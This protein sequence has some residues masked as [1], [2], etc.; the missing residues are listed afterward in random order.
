MKRYIGIRHRVKARVVDGEKAEA[1][2]T[3]VVILE[4]NNE[5]VYELEDETG[6]LDFLRGKFPTATRKVV[7][8]DDLEQFDA[9]QVKWKKLKSL[10]E[11]DSLPP[12]FVKSEGTGKSQEWFVATQVPTAF[13]GLRSGDT[14][15]MVLGGS[16]DYFAFALSVQGDKLRTGGGE[17]ATVIRIPPFTLKDH[18]PGEKEDDARNLALL[19]RDRADLFYPV[20]VRD[21]DL[22]LLGR[23]F[24]ARMDAMRERIKCEQRLYQ[25]AIGGI[26]CRP[27]GEFPQGSIEKAFADTKANDKIFQGLVEEEDKRAK[28]LTKLM[29][30]IPIFDELFG[31]VTGVGPMI[32]AR[33]IVAIGDIRR[34]VKAPAKDKMHGLLLEA[35]EL[36]KQGK[37]EEDLDKIPDRIEKMRA[38]RLEQGF[39]G[40]KAN[41][42][43]FQI[44]QS[45]RSWKQENGKEDEALLLD[46]AIECHRER[47][48]LAKRARHDWA[49]L[50]A[51]CGVH[52]LPDGTFPRKRKGVVA[53]WS[54][55]A[56]Q[57]LYLLGDQF[58]RRPETVWGQ[59]LKANKA[60]YRVKHPVTECSSCKVAWEQ[61]SKDKGKKHARRYNDGHIHK[62]AIWRTLSQF[63]EWLGDRWIKVETQHEAK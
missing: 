61:C 62:M 34:F 20:K 32:A 12:H 11:A 58:N 24:R 3:Q 45:V 54:G 51:F 43:H 38:K 2:P 48:E 25:R 33:L 56:R 4:G 30:R 27:D 36:K 10:E 18:R 22:I 9:H 21:R 52:V 19:A 39:T 60:A 31:E 16:G 63:V 35:Q 28:E 17:G 1:R 29:N 53:N 47:Y 49:K 14:V 6:E 46:R 15:G 37:F 26:F 41:P 13:D 57:A 23:L 42:T 44:L 59:K 55:E 7:D 8:G 50:A 5:T 40:E